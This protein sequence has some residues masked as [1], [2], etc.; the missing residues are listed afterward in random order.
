[1]AERVQEG[2]TWKCSACGGKI[3]SDA[4]HCKHCKVMFEGEGIIKDAQPTKRKTNPLLVIGAIILVIV[5]SLYWLVAT[6]PAI[7]GQTGRLNSGGAKVIAARD[8]ATYDQLGAL[9]P[10]EMVGNPNIILVND[11]TPV[12]VLRVEPPRSQVRIT[13]GEYAG[14]EVWV[15]TS[16]V[17]Q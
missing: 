14:Q 2:S 13:D 12:L 16:W 10:A 17:V 5:G 4:P 8:R 11:G 9:T 7:E 15:L 3:R 1:M 6:G